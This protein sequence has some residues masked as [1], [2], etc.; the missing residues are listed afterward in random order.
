[1]EDLKD[2]NEVMTLAEVADFLQLAEKTI[3][4]MAHKG[5]IPAAKVASQWR[6][7]RS[8]IKDWLASQM[9]PVSLPKSQ[10]LEEN[11]IDISRLD[12]IIRPDLI[13]IVIHPGPKDTVLEQLI[14]PIRQ[15]GFALQTE[16]LLKKTLEREKMMTTAIG[17]GVAMPHPRKPIENMFPKPAVVVGICPKGT[18][19]DAIDGQLV[20]LFFLICATCEEVHLRLMAK[21]GWLIQNEDVLS[22]LKKATSR[23]QVMELIKHSV[24]ESNQIQ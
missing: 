7:L 5:Q 13:R 22:K 4:R 8:V 18:N 16:L 11:N 24:K 17:H 23:E 21:I 10:Y 15:S 2:K 19:F 1:M 6:F 14:Y 9:Y 12:G 20:H 3:L